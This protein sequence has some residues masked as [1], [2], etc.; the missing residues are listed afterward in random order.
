M[1]EKTCCDGCNRKCE[2]HHV[3]VENVANLKSEF[4]DLR[5]EIKDRREVVDSRL[6]AGETALQSI[7]SAQAIFFGLLVLMITVA[8]GGFFQALSVGKELNEHAEL[9]TAKR[10]ELHR[11]QDSRITSLERKAD[12]QS[13][14]LIRIEK[15]LDKMADGVGR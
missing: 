13:E 4:D 14:I 1:A 8:G 15:K 10:E 12:A 6:M 2:E 3:R 11:G 5:D 7:K 9:A